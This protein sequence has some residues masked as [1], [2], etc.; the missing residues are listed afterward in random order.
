MVLRGF[1]HATNYLRINVAKSKAA[2]MM[3]DAL[4]TAL[5]D[6]MPEVRE[7]VIW[8]LAWMDHERTPTIL[9]KTWKMETDSRV[10]AEL[11]RITTSL[12]TDNA[13]ASSEGRKVAD[14]ILASALQS[15]DVEVKR[16]ALAVQE[17]RKR[18]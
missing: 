17:N 15:D 9:L 5:L 18:S 10:K 14:E 12:M 3:I 4:E 11:V 1:F 13:G 2:D 16:A 8:P 6:D 7:S